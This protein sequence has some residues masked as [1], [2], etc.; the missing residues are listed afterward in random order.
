MTRTHILAVIALGA[1]ASAARAEVSST[2]II[3]SDYDFRGISQTA[4]KPSL[5]IGVDWSLD[6][7]AYLSAVAGNVEAGADAKSKVEVDIYG[8]YRGSLSDDLSYELSFA[9]YT[10]HPRGDDVDYTELSAGL[11]FKAVSATY[12]YAWD[13]SNSGLAA[14]YVEVNGSVPLPKDFGLELHSG[15][16]FGEYWRG[17]EYFDYAI[18]VSKQVGDVVMN[19]SW[20]DGSDL[21]SARV[22]MDDVFTSESKVVFSVSMTL[23][24][25]H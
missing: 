14:S 16:S 24:L 19:L 23:P 10:F 13:Y 7:G 15:Y 20:V 22:T 4:R 2:V 18:G 9:Q 17:S 12:S 11:S 21:K 8:G 25:K 1:A 3:G 5:Q 6:S